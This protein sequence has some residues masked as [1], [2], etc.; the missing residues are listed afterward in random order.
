MAS[1]SISG[2]PNTATLKYPSS[3]NKSLET[4]GNRDSSDYLVGEE[5]A[6]ITR[7][8]AHMEL[9]R[10]SYYKYLAKR[11]MAD[12]IVIE[13]LKQVDPKN[14][15]LGL[16]CILTECVAMAERRITSGYSV[17]MQR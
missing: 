2:T 14:G 9:A 4:S 5:A 10:L 6:P 17:F 16:D 8:C 15:C 12:D 1:Y 11:V 3:L 13:V 7:T